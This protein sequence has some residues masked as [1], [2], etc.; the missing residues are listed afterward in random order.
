MSP[1]SYTSR[2]Y[3]Y[4]VAIPSI[5]GNVWVAHE[6]NTH[7]YL[8]ICTEYHYYYKCISRIKAGQDVYA[9]STET[10]TDSDNGECITTQL[11]H[12]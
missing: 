5:Y 1:G 7:V 9:A 2:D 3:R 12:G 8:H 6:Y 10:E 11:V 4:L